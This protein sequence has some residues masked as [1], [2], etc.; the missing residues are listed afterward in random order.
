MMIF[1]AGH[2]F[3]FIESRANVN[4]KKEL[5]MKPEIKEKQE[6]RF[7]NT[8]N[9]EK[10]YR[11]WAE[12]L[13][14]LVVLL[15]SIGQEVGGEEFLQKVEEAVF[16][17]SKADA[18]KWKDVAGIGESETSLDCHKIAQVFDAMDDTLANFWD[19]YTEKSPKALEKRVVTCPVAEPFSLAPIICERLILGGAQGLLK[20]LNS[21][22][23]FRFKELMPNGDDA[24]CYRIEI[25]D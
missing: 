4:L 12:N 14:G 1:A 3:W 6:E 15:V 18:Q 10:R 2:K 23:A 16:E 11:A 22:A 20:A 24:C 25:E 13:A 8:E 19:G 21:K 7:S 17:G 5:E 9:M